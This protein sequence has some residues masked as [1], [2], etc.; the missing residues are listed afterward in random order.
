MK[1]YMRALFTGSCI[2]VILSMLC[3]CNSTS[4]TTTSSTPL[5]TGPQTLPIIDTTNKTLYP[6]G[7]IS[8]TAETNLNYTFNIAA[9]MQ[10]VSVTGYFT[11]TGGAPDLIEVYLM[12]DATYAKWLKNPGGQSTILY[13]SEEMSAGELNE[14]NMAPGIYHLI[15]SNKASADLSAAQAVVTK[16][17]LNWT[18]AQ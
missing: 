4:K 6:G 15:F 12:N 5:P 17:D 18:Y 14:S 7:S 9:N 10:N 2:I 1:K 3:A 8:I 16:I 11:C 13:D